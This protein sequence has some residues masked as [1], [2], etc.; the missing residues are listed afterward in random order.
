MSWIRNN[1]TAVL[2]LCGL[3]LFGQSVWLSFV[4]FDFE[5][6]DEFIDRPV[7]SVVV[8]LLLASLVWLFSCWLVTIRKG[9]SSKSLLLWIIGVGVACRLALVFSTPILEIDLYRYLWDGNVAVATGDPY[10]YAPNEFVQWQYESEDPF[11]FSRTQEEHQWLQSFASE[12]DASMQEALQIMTSHFGQFTSPYP[13]VSQAVFAISH[14]SCPAD[15]SLKTRVTVLK[16]WLVL[17]DIAT[18]LVLI[19]ILRKIKLPAALSVVW[20]WCPLV[21]KEFANGGHLDSITIF[22][23]TAFVYFVLRQIAEP[24]R[25]F[26]WSLS[27]GFVLAMA[28]AAK[29]FPIVLAP[30]WAIITIRK[31]SLRT[32]GSGIVSVSL[33]LALMSPML[34]RVLEYQSL[35]IKDKPMPGIL[36]FAE[37]WEMNDFLFMMVIEN[38]KP[39]VVLP[40]GTTQTH[41][42]VVV[43]NEWRSKFTFQESFTTAK[44]ISNVVFLLIVIWTLF[45]CWR[46]EESRRQEM[47]LEC[48]FLT[49]AWFWLLAPTQNPWY[50]CWA[51]PF[52]PFARS[53]IWYL[54]PV[55]TLLYYTRYWFDYQH[56]DT[57]SFDYFVPVIEFG[58][59]L[60]LL[61][62]DAAKN[63]LLNP[64]ILERN[65]S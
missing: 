40:D 2:L 51:M 44:F 5:I 49:L 1:A 42:M 23:S 54:M 37:S 47:F 50:W 30:L 56:S 36:A 15:S 45:R 65:D 35:E 61:L 57:A 55:M 32:L 63:R 28:V 9:D 25:S 39:D 52:L 60:L 58:P 64:G 27:A 7:I 41:W 26:R 16:A 11:P 3:L 59:I 21:L 33:I 13:P 62:A 19:L 46:C 4:S 12:Q 17:F 24:E 8:G 38:L 31:F 53:R 20:F 34:N 10:E 22:L 29:V 6:R 48:T 14:A 43:P 18:G